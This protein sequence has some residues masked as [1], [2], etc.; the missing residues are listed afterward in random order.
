VV[1]KHDGAVVGDMLGLV[2]SEIEG[3]AVVGTAL[4]DSDGTTEGCADG[5]MLGSTVGATVGDVGSALGLIVGGGVTGLGV[6][7]PGL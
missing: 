4:G 2:L 7:S 6:G 1:G 5:T 3:L